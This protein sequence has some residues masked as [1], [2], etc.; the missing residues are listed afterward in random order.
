VH[1]G[2]SYSEVKKEFSKVL[3]EKEYQPLDDHTF[4]FDPKDECT[5]RIIATEPLKKGQQM[6]YHYG[7]CT[8]RFF[9]INY[10]FLIPNN[11]MD[12]VVIRMND[13]QGD[14]KIVL[15][16]REGTQKHFLKLC[17]ELL[18]KQVSPRPA[19]SK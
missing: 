1:L 13:V 6:P 19:P 12:A 9:L 18:T 4:Y 14:E 15:L 2:K 5:M 8:N 7:W 10:G 11:P 16:H 17:R 3:S